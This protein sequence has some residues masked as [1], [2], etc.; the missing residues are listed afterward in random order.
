M[1][2]GNRIRERKELLWLWF[3][4]RTSFVDM[5]NFL[6]PPAGPNFGI[7]LDSFGA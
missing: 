7:S 2:N 1:A 3:T 6:E 4:L 5:L